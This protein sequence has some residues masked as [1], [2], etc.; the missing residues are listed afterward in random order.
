MSFAQATKGF[1]SFQRFDHR[2]IDRKPNRAAPVRVARK[3]IA[4]PFAG[5]MILLQNAQFAATLREY[6][7]V[8]IATVAS[9]VR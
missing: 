4:V 6:W 2:G 8:E 3:Q 7:I 5:N 9:G 1:G